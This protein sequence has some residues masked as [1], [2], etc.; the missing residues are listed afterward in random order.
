MMKEAMDTYFAPAERLDLEKIKIQA[1]KILD[2]PEFKKFTDAIPD[3]FMILNNKR[4]VVFTNSRLEEFLGIKNSNN[5]FGKR[6]GEILNCIHSNETPG[7]CGTSESCSMC[8]AVNAILCGLRGEYSIQ[9]CRIATNDG[10]DALDLKVWTSP[11]EVNG[12]NYTVFAVQDISNEKRRDVLERIFFH[13]IINTAGGLRGLAEIIKESPE[14]INEFKDII[15]SLTES[16][17]DEITSQ[18]QLLQAERNELALSISDVNSLI[19]ISEVSGYYKNHYVADGKHIQIDHNAVSIDF[20]TDE[21]LAKRVIGNILKNALEASPMDATITVNT[22]EDADE[23][24]IVSVNNPTVM[25]REIQLQ[26]F[27][28]SFSTKGTGRGLGTYSM[29]LLME[30]Y[31]N[32]KITFTSNETE[33]TTFFAAFPKTIKL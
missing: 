6:P 9:E 27:Q 11:Y 13:D 22:F 33:G 19:L 26:M 1:L 32:G 10:I 20:L 23:F 2:S 18:R 8:G 21:A 12:E 29:K 16:L 24:I 17:V 28:R 14:D 5:M 15:F 25:P 4:Q 3:I 30:K 7:G 31:L